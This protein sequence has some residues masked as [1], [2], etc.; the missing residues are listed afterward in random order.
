LDTTLK[1]DKDGRIDTRHWHSD[2]EYDEAQEDWSN[3]H[4]SIDEASVQDWNNAYK[5]VTVTYNGVKY[6]E[7]D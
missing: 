4:V 5:S 1:I 7:H 3:K 2:D 6:N